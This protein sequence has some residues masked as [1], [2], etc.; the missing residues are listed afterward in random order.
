MTGKRSAAVRLVVA[1]LLV[2]PAIVLPTAVSSARPSRQ[3]VANAKAELDALNRRL[4]QLVEQYDQATVRLQQ[5]QAKLDEALRAKQTA[6]AEAQQA[7]ARLNERAVAAFTGMGSQMDVLL[8]A[9]SLTD[10]SDRLQFMGALARS[11]TDL[12]A[13]AETAG[14]EATWASDRY[15]KAVAERQTIL[16]EL[17]S[18]KASV[19]TAVAKQQATYESLSQQLKDALAR[20]AA[21]QTAAAAAAAASGDP[22]GGSTGGSTGG[23]GDGSSGGS[24]G[25]P[26]G[27]GDFIPPPNATAAEIAIAAARS[28][29]GTPYL[30]GAADPNVGF[31]CSGLV[32]WAYAKAGIS[33]PHSSAMMYDLV[34]KVPRDA[35]VPGDL[36]FS[37]SPVS[38]VSLY[39]GGGME[40]DAAH[41]GPGGEVQIRPVY[42]QDFVAG[43]RVG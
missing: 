29:I 20:Q 37:Y 42:W 2:L 5:T 4:D 15:S 19:Q 28:V 25:D 39:I 14:Q 22:A 43:G 30:W 24:S 6:E 38:H 27:S 31:D 7:I 23:S 17:A 32:M 40:I 34:P 26:S 10:F 11:D 8:G 1:A 35:L 16:D 18:R 13:R 33:L 3:D 9:Q 36:I 12:A 41:P 21:A